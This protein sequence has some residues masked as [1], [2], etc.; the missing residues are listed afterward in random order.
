MGLAAL[1][2]RPAAGA[3][4]LGGCP[5]PF[6][7]G[8]SP[9]TQAR[10]WIPPLADSTARLAATSG[11]RTTPVGSF[12]ASGISDLWT[13]L[14]SMGFTSPSLIL[15]PGRGR[16]VLYG[17]RDAYGIRSGEVWARPLS[18]DG[19]WRI[20]D[21]SGIPREDH[22]A[23]Y[24]PVRDRMIV[25]GG[26]GVDG[27]VWALS[28][29]GTSGWS[30]IA[31]P[32]VGPGPCVGARAIY[33]PTRD[34]M[35]VYCGDVWAL[36][37]SGT[38]VWTRLAPGGTPPPARSDGAVIFDS[39]RRRMVVV[40]GSGASVF[41]DIWALSLGDT[42]AWT[43]L[44]PG[45]AATPALFTAASAY[46]SAHDRM[47]VMGGLDAQGVTHAETW[48][49]EFGNPPYWAQVVTPEPQPPAR[50]GGRAVYD[51]AGD[52]VLLYGGS[53]ADTWALASD[54]APQWVPIESAS[55]G[56][57]PVVRYLY[58]ASY[59]TR[60]QG[61]I[62]FGGRM[63]FYSAHGSW[64]TVDFG[65]AWRLAPG[66][67][68]RWASVVRESPPPERFGH[69][70]I[71]DPIGDRVIVFGGN[72]AGAP[73][74]ELWQLPLADGMPW[75]LLEAEG[76]PPAAR[77]LHSA[78]YDS[79]R[80][81][82][83]LY[84]GRNDQTGFGDVWALSL[85]GTPRWTPLAVAGAPPLP[86]WGHSAV[87]DPV[88]DRMIVFGGSVPPSDG[89]WQL[90]FSG[91]PCWSPRPSAMNPPVRRLAA[92]AY[93][94]PRQRV[95]LF[96]GQSPGGADLGDTW[97]LPLAEGAEWTPANVSG[98]PAARW[99]S[100]AVYD[101]NSDRVVLLFGEYGVCGDAFHAIYDV[102]ALTSLVA[103]PPVPRLVRL[104]AHPGRVGLT[105]QAE[106]GAVYTATA[107]R[108]TPSSAWASVG[109]VS[110][111]ADGRLSYE[112]GAA[113]PGA[114]YAYRLSWYRWTVASTT[115]DLWV[116]VP[117]LSFTLAGAVPNPA[118][119]SLTVAFTLPDGAEAR[120][121]VVDVA[122]RRVL[123][124][125][126]GELG[127]GDHAL[128]LARP[129]LLAPGVYWVRLKRAGVSLVSRASVVK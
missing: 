34:R 21:R 75:S 60:R 66:E 78:V 70:G 52:R 128:E 35:I 37:L 67:G 120:L 116:D 47:L 93:D 90:T 105:W 82:M 81:R 92:M 84:G 76:V 103:T 14:P 6:E 39:A 33:D 71:L 9:V 88:G 2:A 122:G 8:A 61:V 104:D 13:R 49:L 18:G 56:T 113:Q 57:A 30:R 31:A 119:R 77:Y 73:T 3:P 98:A 112:D 53:A 44:A 29:S 91:T 65:D 42:L 117:R 19:P 28:F 86:R 4:E 109:T 11:P 97:I 68:S 24:D 72:S 80:R 27:S 64:Y 15:D 115:P 96:G 25:Y 40:S 45:G 26:W 118:H 100:A 111:D 16:I 1:L 69:S 12:A 87:Y 10:S 102:W 99:G 123:A 20:V 62:T 126:V 107:E 36:G 7:L 129:G 63:S 41:P 114:R 58:S 50:A 74:N 48:A 125:E 127:P 89:T 106:P 32:D 51:P 55:S 85:E 17:G 22:A 94:P 59:D 121:E 46:D 54:G 101:P 108:R 124:R 43:Q 38:P 110:A 95:V 23:I 79:T 5:P 83:I